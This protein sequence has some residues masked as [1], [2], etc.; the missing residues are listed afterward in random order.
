M[1]GHL[2]VILNG[3]IL[4]PNIIVRFGQPVTGRPPIFALRVF[5]NQYGKVLDGLVILL[6]LVMV[7]AVLI[8]SLIT[9]NKPGHKCGNRIAQQAATLGRLLRLTLFPLDIGGNGKSLLGF[10]GRLFDPQGG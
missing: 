2:G 7:N 8:I 4:V 5:F 6:P 3:L 9:E 10:G 1:G